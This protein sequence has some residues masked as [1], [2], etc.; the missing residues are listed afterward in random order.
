ME[1]KTFSASQIAQAAREAL[2][3]WDFSVL[4]DGDKQRAVLQEVVDRGGCDT[5]IGK[6]FSDVFDWLAEYASATAADL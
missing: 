5:E 1:Q 2:D 4:D 6:G 3:N